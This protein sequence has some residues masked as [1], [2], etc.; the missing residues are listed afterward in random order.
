MRGLTLSGINLIKYILLF[1]LLFLKVLSALEVS[2][3]FAVQL[4]QDSYL[5]P[6]DFKA[7]YKNK[8]LK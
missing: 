3:A 6:S 2:P 7:K 8:A 5:T 1:T 4:A